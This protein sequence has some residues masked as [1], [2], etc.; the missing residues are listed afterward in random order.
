M[1]DTHPGRRQLLEWEAAKPDNY[2][3]ADENLQ[4]VL[5]FYMGRDALDAAEAGFVDFGGTMATIVDPLLKENEQRENLPRLKRYTDLGERIEDVEFHPNYHEA[6]RHIWRSGVLAVQGDTGRLFEQAALFYLTS[7]AG[8]GGHACPLACTAG[9]I[10]ALQ[11]HGSPELKER[12]LPPLLDRDYDSAHRGAQF[13]TE[14]QGGSDVGAN[15]VRAEQDDAGDWHIYG[16]KWFC[17]VIDADQFLMTARPAGAPDGTRGLGCFL[18]PRRLPDGSLN[19]F[20]VRRLK[21][22]IGTRLMASAETD[23]DGA[24]AYPIGALDQGFKIAAG[25]VLNTSRWLNAL[26]CAGI[27]RRAHIE[28]ESYARHRTAFG[29]H[30]G[31]YPMVQEQVATIRTLTEATLASTFYLTHLLNKIELGE[32][33]SEEQGFYRF[34]VNA[35]KYIT[36]LDASDVV[37]RAIDVL[38]GNGAIEEFSVL[39]RLYRDQIVVENWEGTPNVLALQVL[40]DCG[41]RDLLDDVVGHLGDMFLSLDG[42]AAA[43]LEDAFDA[44]I[45]QVERALREPAYGQAHARRLVARL[46]RTIQAALLLR[47]ADWEHE[48]ELGNEKDEVVEFFIRCFLMQNDPLIDEGWNQRVAQVSRLA[49]S[50]PA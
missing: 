24:L 6:G 7:H 47:E 49:V 23:F 43:E 17:S 14:I 37:H 45:A 33:S 26:A 32:A 42:L 28:A 50:A 41:R 10:R 44:T 12:Y 25:L 5:A 48:Q 4:R 9:L 19:R 34:L 27:M 1:S 21:D 38:G 13:L 3:T 29:Q 35:N 39:P 8:E 20:Y 31:R 15:I 22:K 36:A 46:M 18:V 2:Y 11:H 40:R 30:I 16:E